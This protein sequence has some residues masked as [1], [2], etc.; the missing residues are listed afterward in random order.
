MNKILSVLG[1]V[2]LASTFLGIVIVKLINIQSDPDGYIKYQQTLGQFGLGEN[3]APLLILIELIGGVALFLGFKTK[4]SAYLLAFLSAFM[5]IV[6]GRFNPD[7]LFIYLGLTGGFLTLALNSNV[8]FS[9]DNM[10][11]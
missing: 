2:L 7:L 3:F 10:K 6:L 8:P 11:K 9:I 1:R 4:I 5:A